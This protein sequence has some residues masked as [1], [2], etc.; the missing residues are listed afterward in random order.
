MLDTVNNIL[1]LANGKKINAITG[2]DWVDPE[3]I[4]KIA[5][6]SYL[7]TANNILTMADGTKIDTVTGLIV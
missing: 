7:N 1:T 4:I 5:N 6:G 3:S 2:A